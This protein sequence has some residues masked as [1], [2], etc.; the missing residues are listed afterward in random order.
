[1]SVI[2]RLTDGVDI[3]TISDV[4]GKKA[5]DVSIAD[6]TLA[7]ID[8][9]IE[10]RGMPMAIVVDEVSSTLTYVGEAVPGTLQATALW[11]IKRISIAAGVTTIEWADGD[12][13]FDNVFS[14]R[15]SLAYS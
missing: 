3:A 15:A 7:A 14:N 4:N 9:S 13:N 10:T 2:T 1:M 5:I 11:R 12:S 6:I 8:D